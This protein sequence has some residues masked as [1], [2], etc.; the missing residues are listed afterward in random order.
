MAYLNENY[1]KLQAGY[2]FPEI[3]RRVGEFCEQ[4]PKAAERLIRC[5]IGD[6]TEPLPRAAVE[7]MKRAAEE[8]GHRETFRGYGPEQGYEFLRSTIAQK[9]YR[10]REID[11]ADDEIFVSEGS[12]SDCGYILDILGDQNKVAITDPVYPVY[13][14]T[15]VMTGH[16][17]AARKDGSF[18]G[19][20]YL[21]CTAANNFVPEPPK[22][23]I[24]LVYLCFPNNPTGAVATRDQ[25]ARWVDYARQHDALI[26]FDA[27]YEAYIS[28]PKISHSIFEI[29]GARECAVEFRSFSKIGGF[30]GVRCG[31]TVMPKT[32]LAGT[33]SGKKLPLHPL[34]H[35]R[36]ST[37]AN[38]VSYPVQRGAEALYSD[39]GRKQCLALIEHYMG[40]AKILSEACEQI[41]L[42]VYGGMNAP[43]IWVQT[44]K[45]LTSWELFDRMLREINVVVTPGAGFGAQGE[46]YFRV[47]AFN[48][49]E[50]AEEVARRLKNFR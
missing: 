24:D 39:K 25:L 44:P 46:G 37:K 27:A 38:S 13:V 28:D 23:H 9:D 16:T 19:I 17:G 12:K 11:V 2:L 33:E 26:L 43:Y 6:V 22:E 36:W 41:G 4:N 32:L 42:Q 8:L 47:S 10:D 49:R 34:W 48:S 50:N 3:A 31:F 29:E 30:T 40:N 20:V 21:P 45:G 14:D 5:G 7:A 35:R 15:N 18:E 1:L